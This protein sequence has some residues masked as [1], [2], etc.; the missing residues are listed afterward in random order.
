MDKTVEYF[1]RELRDIKRKVDLMLEVAGR[2]KREQ[3][4]EYYHLI[5]ATLFDCL[6][7]LV[8]KDT[9]DRNNYLQGLHNDVDTC[10]HVIPLKR[11]VK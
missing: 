10:L 5:R 1:N 9:N 8:D 11:D 3:G 4:R 7:S 2:D 6:Q